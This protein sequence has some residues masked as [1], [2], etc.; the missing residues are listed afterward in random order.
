MTI[1]EIK[2][3][4]FKSKNPDWQKLQDEVVKLSAELTASERTAFRKKYWS[5]LEAISMALLANK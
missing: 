3:E 2:D 5:L 4:V 1:E